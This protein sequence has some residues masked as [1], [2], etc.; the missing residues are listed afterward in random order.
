[1]SETLER[2]G[3]PRWSWWVGGGAALAVL[4]LLI[5]TG[6][7]GDQDAP[8]GAT[9]TET[10]DEDLDRQLAVTL[11]GLAPE[12]L[13]VSRDGKALVDDLNIWWLDAHSLHPLPSADDEAAL[14]GEYLG[15]AARDESTAPQFDLRDTGHVRNALLFR[16][17]AEAVVQSADTDLGRTVA[18]F[19]LASRHIAPIVGSATRPPRTAFESLVYGRGRPEDCAWV[20][21]EILRQLR[22]DCVVLTPRSDATEPPPWLV[23]AVIPDAGVYL[24][25]PALRLPVPSTEGAEASSLVDQPATLQEALG[26][27]QVFRQLDAA[28]RPYPLT[29]DELA[30]CSVQAITNSSFSAARMYSL[31]LSLPAEFRATLFEGLASTSQEQRGLLDRIRA[32]DS[33]ASHEIGVWDYPEQQTTDFYASGGEQG[34]DLQSVFAVLRAPRVLRRQ[35]SANGTIQVEVDAQRPLRFVRVEHLK[36]EF[37][38]ALQH[39]GAIRSAP[40]GNSSSVNLEASEFAAYWIAV[41]QYEMHRDSAAQSNCDL[42]RRLYPQG[43]WI[44]PINEISAL[45]LAREG[46]WAEAAQVLADA[47]SPTLRDLY[48][49]HKWRSR[50]EA[51]G[52]P[53]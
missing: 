24:F 19:E 21:A 6:G 39:Y 22:I 30:N 12:N 44:Q 48:L 51:A 42:Y 50:G 8:E 43:L 7:D 53:E 11:V 34:A 25:D 45:S 52:E 3:L 49:I 17:I 32:V 29:S 4:L 38:E 27:D 10:S 15:P 5:L 47:P 16:S 46:R 41:C 37:A 33:L 28:E 36:G 35:P 26:N 40:A 2:R 31:E 9:T 20:F 23:G 1:M 13:G 14:A 18:A